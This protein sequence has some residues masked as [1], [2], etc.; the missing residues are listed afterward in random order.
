MKYIQIDQ[1]QNSHDIVKHKFPGFFGISPKDL[2]KKQLLMCCDIL[3][4]E[5]I[6]QQ[7]IYTL[8]KKQK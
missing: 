6:K 1:L 2:N 7:N 3:Y 5:L 8:L 4:D